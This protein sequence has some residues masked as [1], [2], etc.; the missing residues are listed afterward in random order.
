MTVHTQF[1]V[2]KRIVPFNCGVATVND[3]TYLNVGGAAG[4]RQVMAY[5]GSLIGISVYVNTAPGGGGTVEFEVYSGSDG[6]SGTG[7]TVSITETDKSGYTTQAAGV[8]TFEAGEALRIRCITDTGS[9]AGAA[10][11]I[12][13]LV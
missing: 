8:T 9:A 11:V 3:G 7:L 1:P 12:W 10:G 13:T 4:G 5:D 2:N 6:A